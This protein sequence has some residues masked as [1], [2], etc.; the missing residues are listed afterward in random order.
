MNFEELKKTHRE[1]LVL[2]KNL[3]ISPDV[4]FYIKGNGKLII[5]DGVSIGKGTHIEVYRDA[6]LVLMSNSNIGFNCFIS[7][8][9]SIVM[10][11]GS[12]I[13]NMVDMHDHNHKVRDLD[14]L[15]NGELDCSASGFSIAPIII[16]HGAVISNKC[17][18]T[19]GVRVGQ[20]SLVGANTVVTK[21]VPPNTVSAGT[22]N[23]Q[24]KSFIGKT[25][26]FEPASRTNIA[27]F[28]TSLTQHLEA[29]IPDMYDQL[30]LPQIDSQVSVS[31][32]RKRGFVSI[33][34]NRFIASKPYLGINVMN[35][36]KGG[37]N[38]FKILK[39]INKHLPN[40]SDLD[41]AFLECGTNDIL[42]RHQERMEDAV[43]I[44]QFRI[45]Y[46]ESIKK[47]LKKSRQVICVSVPPVSENFEFD[48]NAEIETYNQV[49]HQLASEN[50]CLFIDVY[51][52]FY[53]IA[54]LLDNE[55]RGN[56]WSDGLHLAEL[57]DT[58]V[59]NIIFEELNE[60]NILDAAYTLPTVDKEI[61][62]KLYSLDSLS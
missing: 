27:F 8:M 52:K 42:R 47:L 7:T 39:E 6:T 35:Y 13:S 48:M 61:G 33:L 25:V 59:A 15:P 2:G 23:K 36:G 9:C 31:E 22:P 18:L 21:S 30:N 53:S 40:C 34:E 51:S 50:G 32:W 19:A 16:E 55:H 10:G 20:N 49:I 29:Y 4:S 24:I 43:D 45:N 3:N 28:G 17:T 41:I 56:L 57:G 11:K 12:A 60:K 26:D 14:N 38:S 58:T 37:A 1:N 44:R 54:T 62:K 5:E 46:E